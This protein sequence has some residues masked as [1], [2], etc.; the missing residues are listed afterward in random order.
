MTLHGICGR[1]AFVDLN[2]GDVEIERPVPE[3]YIQYLGGYGLAGYYLYR[4]Q[5]RN[6]PPLGERALLGFFTAPLTGTEAIT[7]NRFTVVGASPK[8][9]GFGDANCGGYFGPALKGA[10]L[11]GVYFHGKAERPVYAMI[12][13]GSVE[14]RDAT[15]LWGLTCTATERALQNLHGANSQCAVIGPAGERVSA[16]ACVINDSGRA[17]GRSGLGM[18][19]GAK[20]LKALVALPG[21]LPPVADPQGVRELRRRIIRE[22]FTKDNLLFQ[23]F[24]Q[25]GTPAAIASNVEI[26][27]APV[28]NWKGWK[29]D[30]PNAERI[31]APCHEPYQQRVYACWK[32][33]VACGRILKVAQGPYACETH[34]P[35]YETLGAF[36]SMCC[37]DNLESIIKCNEL[38][39]EYGMD[40]ISAGCTVAFAMECF[41]LGLVTAQDAG[42]DLGW[43]NH[44]SIVRMTEQLATG[45]GFL[46]R[47]FGHGV[48]YAA[49]ILGP[50][51]QQA[52]MH[53]GGE[54]LP[55]H[56]P[57]CFP[58]LA[59]S[60]VADATPGRHTQRGSWSAE[61]GRKKLPLQDS[62]EDQRFHFPPIENRYVYSGKGQAHRQMS[63]LGHVINASGICLFGA[64]LCPDDALP[65]FLSLVMGHRFSSEA[66]LTTGE[67]I[68]T[69]RLAFN[70]RQG[71]R[72]LRD[73][74]LPPRVLGS[75]PMQHGPL[76]DVNVDNQTQLRDYYSAMGW[77]PDSGLPFRERL[78]ELG[79]DFAL[80][81][82]A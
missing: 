51:A 6:C 5:P 67:R 53:C 81:A 46:G 9:Q 23:F 28:M 72:N 76:Q 22:R 4:R 65:R 1:I 45:Q 62:P 47:V 61:S 31:D 19:M 30:F 16:L 7:G 8:T 55:M 20:R 78:Q 68:A 75:P 63:A 36:G 11:D 27:D 24:R 25:T 60:Y 29:A 74:T 57:R 32:C 18:S 79:L 59:A 50:E 42:M 82:L 35:E 56:D 14:L 12:R 66:L 77:D 70:L 41:E 13:D 52:A 40:T 43:G 69:L 17:A 37:N 39:N 58:G 33:P 34:H 2:S 54:E 73:Y 64:M 26:G 48:R 71:V 44:E 15:D 49:E 80:D 10:G 21:E 3:L 38:C